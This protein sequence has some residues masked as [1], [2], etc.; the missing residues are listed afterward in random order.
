VE[1]WVN[2]HDSGDWIDART[3]HFVTGRQTPMQY[4]LGAQRQAGPDTLDFAQ[5]RE[6]IYA[7]ERT[8]NIHGGNLDHPNAAPLAPIGEQREER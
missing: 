3:A 6:H 2:E 4:G 8:F 1:L 5:A 7:V